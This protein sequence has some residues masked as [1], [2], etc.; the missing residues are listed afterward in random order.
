MKKKGIVLV[1][2]LMAIGYAIVV[3]NMYIHGQTIISSSDDFNV[4]YSNALVNEIQDLSIVESDRKLVFS[5]NFDTLGQ[6]YILDYDVTNG[7]ANYDAEL[8]MACTGGNEYLS[9]I[10]NFDDKSILE[11][12]ETRSGRLTLELVKSYTGSDMDVT[13]ECEITAN[14][15]ER[16]SIKTG[17]AKAS[18]EE[19]YSVGRLL[20]IGSERFNVISE[21][22]EYVTLLAQYTLD[23]DYRQN[24]EDNNLSFSD[25]DGW[26]YSPGPKE[27][28]IQ[29][30]DGNVKTYL[31]EYVSYLQDRTNDTTITGTLI[32]L[33]EL[34]NLGCTINDDYSFSFNLTCINSK[35]A[36]WLVNN[37]RFWT[38]S[39]EPT[40]GNIWYVDDLGI[41]YSYSYNDTS[42]GIRPVIIVSKATLNNLKD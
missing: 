6:K 32:T 15:L 3:T 22:D 28:D 13:I 42:I 2:L 40:N 26:E 12:L 39:T 7:S 10:N 41:I 20:F 38:R 33:S 11:S 29:S 25:T 5:T 8:E 21:D 16:D 9:V 35:Y 4:Y 37:Q 34:K 23:S 27:I 30:Y 1:I 18:I 24:S 14:A 31:Q 19:D 36:S 17:E